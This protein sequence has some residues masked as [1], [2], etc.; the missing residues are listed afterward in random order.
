MTA[1]EEAIEASTFKFI[2]ELERR[3]F[4]ADDSTLTGM[5]GEDADAVRVEIVLPEDFPFA[6]PV[7]SP[8]NDFPRS[9]TANVAGPCACTRQTVE[10]TCPGW[11]WMSSSHSSS[12][13]SPSPTS[14]WASDF[15]DLDLERYF[16][17]VDEP[18]VVY[19]DLDELNNRFV[20]LRHSG[21]RHSRDGAWLDP[22][23]EAGREGP[24]LRLRHQHRRTGRAA[25]PAG[26]T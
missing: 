11:S 17:Q 7:V 21:A 9:G 23:E 22:E 16:E 6:P 14:G 10:R 4:R 13:G 24:C 2:E 26:M 18:L 20:Q 3:G 25:R 19:G 12:A 5:V 8:P 15:P 1:W